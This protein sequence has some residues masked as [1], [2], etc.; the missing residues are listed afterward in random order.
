M[1]LSLTLL[2][3]SATHV[4]SQ[5]LI[6]HPDY[7]NFELNNECTYDKVLMNVNRQK[8]A[9]IADQ[10][11]ANCLNKEKELGALLGL[12]PT[13]V[14]DMEAKINRICD[15]AISQ[16]TTDTDYVVK[17]ED[18]PLIE[19]TDSETIN[20]FLDEFYDGGTYYNEQVQQTNGG[21]SYSLNRDTQGIKRFY[22]G[23]AQRRLVDWPSTSVTN[24]RDCAINAVMCCW[25]QDRQADDNNG[26]CEQPYPNANIR[27]DELWTPDN[28]IDKDP[29]DNTDICYVDMSRSPKSNHVVEGGVIFDDKDGV[30]EGDTHCHGLAWADDSLSSSHRYRG[31][32]LFFVSMY[33]HMRQRGYVRN[34]PGAP[35]CGCIEQ[36][37]TV[38]R[39]DCTEMD[40]TEDFS[41]TYDANASTF[42]AAV[43]KAK[44][45]FNACQGLNGNNNNLQAYYERLVS[46]GEIDPNRNAEKIE[47][48]LVGDNNCSPAVADFLDKKFGIE[49]L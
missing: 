28:C 40:I 47:D 36:M 45:Q 27:S 49:R 41:F 9:L 15:N 3:L 23:P 19:S 22:N 13:N 21:D 39:S 6:E 7:A 29:A 46:E 1:K 37:P 35:M 30:R 32:N 4:F 42:N 5:C 43:I 33:D 12:D 10:G 24:F 18:I 2:A 38:T 31:N 14:S 48:Y 34:I 25:A 17:F 8:N 26:N 16:S 44:I 20:R 11:V